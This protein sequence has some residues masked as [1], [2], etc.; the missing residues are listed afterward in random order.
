MA[1]YK[2]NKDRGKRGRCTVIHRKEISDGGNM[3][4]AQSLERKAMNNGQEEVSGTDNLEKVKELVE[5]AKYK[6]RRKRNQ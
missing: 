4:G 6:T 5:K 2:G 3:K 1:E